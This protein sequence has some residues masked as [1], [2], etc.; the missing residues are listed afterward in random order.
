MQNTTIFANSVRK[1][2][3]MGIVERKLRQKEEVRAAILDTAWQLVKK[4]G[5][6]QLS[7][8]K[9][10]DAIEYSVPVIYDHFENKEAILFEIGKQGFQLLSKKMQQAKDKHTDPAEQLKAMADAYWNFAFKNK[11]YYQL[12]FGLGMPCCEVEKNMPEKT[13]FRNLVMGS[14]DEIIKKNKVPAKN[15]CLKYHTF[16][17]VIHGLISMKMMRGSDAPDDLNKMVLDDAVEGII[18]NLER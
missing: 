6:Q 14:I 3:I 7:I 10:A 12:M 11:E 18:K 13:Y 4:E 2:D 17:S 5:W 15:A 1:S 16:W 9:I 8:R